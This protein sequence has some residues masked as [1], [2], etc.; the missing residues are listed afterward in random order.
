MDR[1]RGHFVVLGT[2]H[3]LG[4]YNNS[5]ASDTRFNRLFFALLHGR[6]R[7]CFTRSVSS[8][9]IEWSTSRRVFDKAVAETLSYEVKEC[10]MN[11]MMK[12]IGPPAC[13]AL[14]KMISMRS[15]KSICVPPLLLDVPTVP[16][17]P[18]PPPTHT[19]SRLWMS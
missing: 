12:T 6:T 15:G 3:C 14:L 17:N 8:R 4:V 7:L 18:A 13:S 19:P 9:F 1:T 5:Q 16:S 10:S 11:W 2:P